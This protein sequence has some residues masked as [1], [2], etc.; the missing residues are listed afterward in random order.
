MRQHSAV[1][2]AV[3][4]VTSMVAVPVAGLAATG[5]TSPA[6]TDDSADDGTEGNKTTDEAANDSVAP[7]E[8]FAGVVGVQEAEI[9]G[10]VDERAFGIEVAKAGTND[11]AKADAVN[12]QL[13]DVER[14]LDRLEQRKQ[15]LNENRENMSEGRYRAEMSQVAARLETTKR[16]AN[17][18]EIVSRSLP[19]DVLE[20][21]VNATAIRTLQERASGLGGPDITEIARRIA[22]PSV[23]GPPEDRGPDERPD[24]GPDRSADRRP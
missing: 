1:V 6:Q 5:E 18:S 7:G 24:R 17:Q 20:S 19:T 2:L 11:S 16:L 14:R 4:L 12:A 23:G 21:K 9:E 13:G 22:G 15:E 8:R 10:E 3:L